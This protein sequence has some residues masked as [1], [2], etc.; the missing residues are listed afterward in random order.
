MPAVTF[1]GPVVERTSHLKYL[2]I[3]FDRMLT[4]RKHVET[5][6]MKHMKGLSV[7]KSMAVKGIPS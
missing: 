6:P 3:H 1:N 2:G 7:L 4:Y 5:T